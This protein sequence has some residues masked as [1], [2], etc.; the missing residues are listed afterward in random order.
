MV[1][2]PNTRLFYG[3]VLLRELS[4][5]F[6]SNQSKPH[7]KTASLPDCASGDVMRFLSP[8]AVEGSAQTFSTPVR[9]NWS[10]SVQNVC[11]RVFCTCVSGV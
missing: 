1:L 10:V 9:L 2:V 3:N 4:V 8:S 6:S 5:C 7:S 11:R